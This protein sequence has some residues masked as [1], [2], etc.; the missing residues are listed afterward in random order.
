MNNDKI[1]ENQME[2]YLK[3]LELE[4]KNIEENYDEKIK[5]INLSNEKLNN[6]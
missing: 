1:K 6:Q 3:N 4:M 5:E 2:S